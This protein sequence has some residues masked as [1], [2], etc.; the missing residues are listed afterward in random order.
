MSLAQNLPHLQIHFL[1]MHHRL[2]VGLLLP[3]IAGAPYTSDCFTFLKLKYIFLIFCTIFVSQVYRVYSNNQEIELT[4]LND[5]LN[6]FIDETKVM[7][8]TVLCCAVLC[9]TVSCR[10]MLCCAVM[11]SAVLRFVVLC[12][13]LPCCTVM[14]LAVLYR[15][16]TVLLL[17]FF[18]C[19]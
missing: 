16:F 11:C 4:R 9:C 19:F 5:T 18:L 14:C 6:N 12:C 15:T 2:C 7:F 10:A 3:S 13:T 1:V 17:N 8:C